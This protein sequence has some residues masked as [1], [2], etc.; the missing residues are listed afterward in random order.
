ML[1]KTHPLRLID[2]TMFV[3]GLEEAQRFSVAE[4]EDIN[5]QFTLRLTFFHR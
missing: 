1:S 5:N 2:K 4:S 3:A